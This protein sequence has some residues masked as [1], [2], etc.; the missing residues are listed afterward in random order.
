MHT[1]GVDPKWALPLLDSP[2]VRCDDRP[3]F[4]DLCPLEGAKSFGRLLLAEK[5][6]VQ[7]RQAVV[8]RSHQLM[9]PRRRCSVSQLLLSG[10]LSGETP[11]ASSRR[12][13]RANPLRRLSGYRGHGE[14]LSRYGERLNGARADLRKRIGGRV[15]HEIDLAGNRILHRRTEAHAIGHEPEACGRLLLEKQT[16]DR[17]NTAR[18]GRPLG[19]AV[20]IR[21]SASDELLEIARRHRFPGYDD[22]GVT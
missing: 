1:H 5:S 14:P 8:A 11:P 22:Q 3:P 12:E 2:F 21:P 7:Y 17:R 9:R 10:P 15:D 19:C 20:G 18:A 6:P 13:A 4:L 16:T